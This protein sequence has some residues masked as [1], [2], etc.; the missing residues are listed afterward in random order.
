MIIPFIRLVC[1]IKR[2]LTDEDFT[3][4]FY[5]S[6]LKKWIASNSKG[7][8]RASKGKTI[9]AHFQ[10]PVQQQS[11]SKSSVPQTDS[12]PASPSAP[13]LD[14]ISHR[15]GMGYGN[16]TGEYRTGYGGMGMYNAPYSGTEIH[17]Y[18]STNHPS[19]H[20]APPPQSPMTTNTSRDDTAP[21]PY[22]P[23]HPHTLHPNH[24]LP[25]PLHHTTTTGYHSHNAVYPSHLTYTNNSSHHPHHH[26]QQVHYHQLHHQQDHPSPHVPSNHHHHYPYYVQPVAM[27]PGGG[28][29][30]PIQQYGTGSMQQPQKS[31]SSP[32]HAAHG[33]AAVHVGPYHVQ[34]NAT[35]HPV[36]AKP[37]PTTGHVSTRPPPPPP[38]AFPIAAPGPGPGHA[39]QQSPR[40]M[41]A[42]AT[43][44]TNQHPHQYY[45]NYHTVAASS[46]PVHTAAVPVYVAAARQL[47]PPST[48]TQSAAATVQYPPAAAGWQI[49]SSAHPQTQGQLYGRVGHQQASPQT[50]T[51]DRAAGLY[52]NMQYQQVSRSR[53]GEEVASADLSRLKL[54]QGGGMA[55]YHSSPARPGDAGQDGYYGYSVVLKPAASMVGFKFNTEAILKASNQHQT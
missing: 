10:N 2:R 21:I 42:A 31:N 36:V 9:S 20:H 50:R 40:R 49:H 5:R 19:P 45:Q 44:S 17:N 23:Q 16:E 35:P 33:A 34:Q 26:H 54:E 43:T 13:P 8:A 22:P 30:N 15:Y 53:D 14:V 24:T 11:H 38:S 41:L 25:A 28:S 39:Q 18:Q 32:A 51:Q 29:V 6:Q 55:R 7:S 52:D 48:T 4:F 47:F 1:P 46:V 27:Y 12:K 37:P 3:V